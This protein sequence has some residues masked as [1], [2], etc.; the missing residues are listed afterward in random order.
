MSQDSIKILKNYFSIPYGGHVFIFTNKITLEDIQQNTFTE[1][2]SH[3]NAPNQKSIP[4]SIFNAVSAFAN[5]LNGKKVL[6][7]GGNTGY[8]SFL[9]A[10]AGADVTM[11]ERLERQVNVAYAMADVRGLKLKIFNGL[12]QDYLDLSSEIFDCT[13]MLNMFDQMLRTDEAV[14]WKVLK[15]VSE[16]CKMLFLMMGATEQIPTAKGLVT[17]TPHEAAPAISRFNKPDYEVI[18]EKTVYTNYKVLT[19]NVYENRELQVYW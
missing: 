10:E 16:R 11:T 12:I 8:F 5:G 7:I 2:L 6:D 15:Q 14:A 19:N 9:A 13:L 18:L 4:M 17:S 3:N 1:I